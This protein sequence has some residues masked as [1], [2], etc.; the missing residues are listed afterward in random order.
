MRPLPSHTKKKGQKQWCVTRSENWRE[1]WCQYWSFV[2]LAT[3]WLRRKALIAKEK[4]KKKNLSSQISSSAHWEHLFVLHSLKPRNSMK[5]N[6]Q[7]VLDFLSFLKIIPPFQMLIPSSISFRMSMCSK[8]DFP[9]HWTSCIFWLVLTWSPLTCSH[10]QCSGE[11]NKIKKEWNEIRFM[12]LHR[13]WN[14]S[15]SSFTNQHHSLAEIS[16][17]SFEVTVYTSNVI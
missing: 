12:F 9:L 4:K 17:L 3:R 7:I 14:Q 6:W 1:N 13:R 10:P 16:V 5:K 2:S 8:R 15:Y 11:N